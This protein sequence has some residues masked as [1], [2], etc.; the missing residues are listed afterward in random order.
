MINV[1]W[2]YLNLNGSKEAESHYFNCDIK[3]G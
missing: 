3:G 2:V 1:Y